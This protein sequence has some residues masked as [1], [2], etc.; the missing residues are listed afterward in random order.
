MISQV[1]QL[2]W[3]STRSSG[4]GT[5]LPVDASVKLIGRKGQTAVII[6]GSDIKIVLW[7]FLRSILV[8]SISAVC[9]WTDKIT[10]DPTILIQKYF[11]G[12]NYLRR[13]LSANLQ[14]ICHHTLQQVWTMHIEHNLQA[15]LATL[16]STNFSRQI[17]WFES[18]G[19][20]LINEFRSTTSMSMCINPAQSII[21]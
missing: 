17:F 18:K 19:Y 5:W 6:W 2:T 11:C 10:H 15:V 14:P 20:N 9:L 1:P 8:K 4:W 13:L 3:K 12:E 7:I 16:S 21:I